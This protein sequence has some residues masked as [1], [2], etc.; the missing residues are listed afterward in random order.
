MTKWEKIFAKYFRYKGLSSLIYGLPQWLMNKESVCNAGDPGLIPGSG[1]SLEEEMATHSSVLAQ[2]IPWTE[3]PGD[4][5]SIGLQR[6]R[7]D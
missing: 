3:D 5:L 2:K 4:L 1:R 6:V 7:Q